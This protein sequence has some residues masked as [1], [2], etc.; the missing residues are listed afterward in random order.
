MLAIVSQFFSR[1]LLVWI[2]TVQRHK[3]MTIILCFITVLVSI[4]YTR[5]NLGMNTDT[6]DMLSPDLD[7]RKL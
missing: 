5:N 4:D 3:V 1:A 7:W 6:E 2:N